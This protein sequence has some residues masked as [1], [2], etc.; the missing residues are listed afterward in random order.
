MSGP[1]TMSWAGM[2]SRAG[3][4]RV[5]GCGRGGLHRAVFG[6]GCG[7]KEEKKE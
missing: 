3:E 7:G 1:A 2:E 4:E 6:G 5:V